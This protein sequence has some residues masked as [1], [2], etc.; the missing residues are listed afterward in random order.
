MILVVFS[1]FKDSVI[2]YLSFLWDFSFLNQ[3]QRVFPFPSLG[4]WSFQGCSFTFQ[5]AS[6]FLSQ[7]APEKKESVFTCPYKVHWH[8]LGRQAEDQ[9]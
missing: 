4:L 3:S 7:E 5:I 6:D 9:G 8:L 1:N 2:L